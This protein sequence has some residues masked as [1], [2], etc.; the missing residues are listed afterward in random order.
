[1]KNMKRVSILVLVAL[2]LGAAAGCKNSQGGDKTSDGTGASSGEGIYASLPTGNF[3]GTSFTVLVPTHALSEFEGENSGDTI[4][5][6]VYKRNSAVEDKL[7]VKI[8]TYNVAGTWDDA[9]GFKQT[10]TDA[11]YT[12][13]DSFQLISGYAAYI[14]SLASDGCFFNW[15]ELPKVAL[16]SE[17]WNQSVVDQMDVNNRLYFVTGDLSLSALQYMFCL[18]F[19]KDMMDDRQLEY[20]YEYVNNGNWTYDA[21]YSYITSVHGDLNGDGIYDADN[22]EFGYVVDNENYISAYLAAFDVPITKKDET[23]YPQLTI[24]ED[25]NFIERFQAA[26]ALIRND[27]GSLYAEG[28]QINVTSS[29]GTSIKMFSEK[30]AL[31]ISSCLGQAERL[32]GAEINFGIVPLPKYSERQKEYTTTSW[33]GYTLFCIPKQISELEKVGTVIENLAGYSH[34]LVYPAFVDVTLKG[35]IIDTYDDDSR[36]MVD[37]IRAGATYD[38]GVVNSVHCGSPAHLWRSLVQNEDIGIAS[39]LKSVE[40]NIRRQYTDFVDISYYDKSES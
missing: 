25:E 3:D 6:A 21:F 31:F 16:D 39:E 5:N 1:M 35:K 36:E 4:P 23:G 9:T 8:E 40:S 22:D 29:S 11:Y 20:P 13:D 19:D 37:I 33:D 28:T 30:R 15:N 26:Y 38:F 14:T 17:W 10:I 24:F 7:N 2:M 34:Q 18:F 32:R 12:G 27:E